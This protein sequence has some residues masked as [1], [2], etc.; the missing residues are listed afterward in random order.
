MPAGIVVDSLLRKSHPD[1]PKMEM[2][3]VN[4]KDMEYLLNKDEF[5][6]HANVFLENDGVLHAEIEQQNPVMRIHNGSEQFYITEYAKKIPMS[7]Q[8]S[9]KVLIAEGDIQP[10]NYKGLV[11]LVKI[12]NE[13]NLLKTLVVGIRKEKV[14]SFILLVDDGDYILE[15]G[16][17]ENLKTKLENFE[18]FHSEFIE[19]SAEMPYKRLN[20]RFNN[21]IVASK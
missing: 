16:K 3:R 6:L 1:Y 13:D 18:V 15:L 5:V 4:T 7:N 2:K 9:A 20:L 14:N 17:L 12:I 8:F 21:Q 19:K 10:K 11:E